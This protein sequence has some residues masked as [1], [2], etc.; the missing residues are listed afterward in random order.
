[1]KKKPR[2]QTRSK[3][4]GHGSSIGQE[5]IESLT[6]LAEVLEAG[7]SDVEHFTART[8][9][10]PDEPATYDAKAV[11]QTRDTIGVSQSVFAR[12]MGVSV[13][14]VQAWERGAR[15]PA[16][17]ARRLLDEINRDPR[18]WRKMLMAK[19]G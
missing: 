7:G 2:I 5:I 16:L 6:E 3:A 9:E 1:M 18:H 15:V 19:A 4:R 10:M 11:R 14:L 13:V 17:W 12:L 8:I